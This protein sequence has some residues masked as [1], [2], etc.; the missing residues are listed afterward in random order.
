MRFDSAKGLQ[1]IFRRFQ[2]NFLSHGSYGGAEVRSEEGLAI[3]SQQLGG[4]ASQMI[5]PGPIFH[6]KHIRS[7][8]GKMVVGQSLR[9]RFLIYDRPPSHVDEKR[10]FP[11]FGDSFGIHQ[12]NRIRPERGCQNH[13]LTQTEKLSKRNPAQ[14]QSQFF[15]PR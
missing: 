15:F 7:V 10:S 14:F 4:N 3:I 9:H 11:H 13:E 1:N 6:F 8:A 12:V 2:L 5:G